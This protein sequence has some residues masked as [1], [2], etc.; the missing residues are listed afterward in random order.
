MRTAGILALLLLLLLPLSLL[1]TSCQGGS[2]KK[3]PSFA[4]LEENQVRAHDATVGR[5]AEVMTSRFCGECHPAIYAEHREN[6]HGRAFTDPEVRLATGRFQHS[7]CIRCHTPRPI[8]ET[9]IGMNPVRRHHNLVEGNTCMS[10]HWKKNHDYASFAGGVECR[11]AFDPRV[12]SVEACASCHRNHGTP[13]QWELSPLGK[14]DG[15]RCMDCH[16]R[17]VRRPVA[18]GQEPKLVHS[19][20]FPGSKSERQLRMAYRYE[21]RLDGNEVV[22]K[23]TNKGTGHNFPTEL[24]QRSLESLIIVRDESGE[25]ISRSRMIF[26]DPYKRPYGLMLPVNTQ[27]PSG[28]SREHRVPIKT[29]DGTVDTELHFKLYFPI[30]DHHPDLSRQLE[31]RRLVFSGLTPSDKEVESAPDVRVVVPENI[32]PRLASAANLVDY[33]RPEIGS[34]KLE[35]PE[36]KN[37]AEIKK[38]IELFMFPV[39]EGGRRARERLVKIGLRAV[40]ALIEALGS[41]DN[42]TFKQAMRA[43]QAIGD[44]AV[45]AVRKALSSEQLYIRLHARRLIARM[46]QADGGTEVVTRLLDALVAPDIVDRTSAAEA[47]GRLGVKSAAPALRKLLTDT[48]PDVVRAAAMS[49]ARLQDRASVG[50]IMAAMQRAPFDETR[51]DLAEVLAK[52]GSAGGIP[53]L[54]T[55]LDDHD[56]LQREAAFESLYRVTGLHMGYDPAAPAPLRLAAISRLRSYWASQGSSRA[57]RIQHSPERKLAERAWKLVKKLA[58]RSDADG[59]AEDRKIMAELLQLGHA[60]M[61]ALIKGLKYPPG[62]AAKRAL[63]CETIGRIGSAPAAPFLASTLR[64][65]VV[66]VASW[67]CWALEG[68]GDK[69]VLPAV[70][71]YQARLLTLERSGRLPAGVGPFD[72]LL[73]QAARTRLMLGDKRAKQDLANLLLSDDLVARQRAI[74]ALEASFGETRGYAANA[75]LLE[76]RKAAASW[77]R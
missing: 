10:C 33:V 67:A 62:F 47:L 75:P 55:Q 68:S 45:P 72:P 42:K 64:D 77:Q 57:L 8:F 74:E 38:L 63:I 35:I 6:T 20:V 54:L 11:T 52:L 61:P 1:P 30:E 3:R 51:R 50:E 12:G 34:V 5:L 19:H 22:V 14:G 26:R 76:R 23:I 27:I 65:P 44:P 73:A 17:R 48:A 46:G 56:E 70:R 29:S 32:D 39:P 58:D 28:E 18:T 25:E 4:V 53:V 31:K 66:A 15:R 60:A 2:S 59:K 36:G 7:D 24:K 40:P 16:M 43:L 41:W 13:Y 21:A 71:W 9:G 37:D 69:E 49:L